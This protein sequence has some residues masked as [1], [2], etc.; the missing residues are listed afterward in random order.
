MSL[1]M[2]VACGIHLGYGSKHLQPSHLA[3]GRQLYSSL[4]LQTAEHLTAENLGKVPVA[5]PATG[6]GAPLVPATKEKGDRS[7]SQFME[8]PDV[9]AMFRAQLKDCKS[10]DWNVE[11]CSGA[12]FRL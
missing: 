7:R 2:T 9:P 6:A 1:R 5:A 10:N 12:C 11:A 8:D 4:V 3:D